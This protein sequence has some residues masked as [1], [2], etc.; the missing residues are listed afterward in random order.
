MWSR[1]SDCS[2]RDEAETS[3]PQPTA[4]G[5]F[6]GVI[7]N[8]LL[9]VL[10]IV[11]IAV[12]LVDLAWTAIAVAAGAGPV[13]RA[14]TQAVWRVLT[15]G[16]SSGRRRQ[17]AG[18]VTVV[19]LPLAWIAL[20][21]AGFSLL[22]FAGDRPIVDANKPGGVGALATVAYA[23]GGLA[24]AGAGF[25]ASTGFWELVNNVSALTGLAFFTLAVTFV[26]RVVTAD[27]QARAA[28]WT[29]AGLGSDPY[30]VVSN[31]LSETGG[32]TLSQQIVSASDSLSQVAEQHL[33]LPILRYLEPSQPKASIS[34]SAV[35]F[36]EVLTIIE[37]GL[38][39]DRPL[40]VASG[41]SAVTEFIRTTRT[42]S[43]GGPPPTLTLAP[44]GRHA[45][46]LVAEQVFQRGVAQLEDRRRTLTALLGYGSWD[47]E[48]VYNDRHDAG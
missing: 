25:T 20:L 16:N 6:S 19:A 7:D 45:E 18:Y 9:F 48:K 33:A 40:L 2:N 29:I 24:G 14:V 27:A 35:V 10:G 41:R 28:A 21:L 47:W 30:D 26:L 8:W 1:C 11:V 37:H 34:R 12:T 17:T 5:T 44:L 43:S 13:S 22:Y 46:Q 38:R 15:V 4:V 32:D 39:D 23:A 42:G 36:D 3:R 31:A